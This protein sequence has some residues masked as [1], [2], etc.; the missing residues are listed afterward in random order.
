MFS[1]KMKSEPRWIH[2]IDYLRVLSLHP[3]RILTE[4]RDHRPCCTACCQKLAIMNFYL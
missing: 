1:D 2:E 3:L 4:I